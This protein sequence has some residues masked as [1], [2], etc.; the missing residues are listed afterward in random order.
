MV[1][2]FDLMKGVE[3]GELQEHQDAVS[4]LEFWGTTTLITGG[5]DGQVCIWRAQDWELLLKY[6][7]HKAAVACLAVHPSGRLMASSGR[8]RGIRLW[9]LTRGTAAATLSAEDSVEELH[10]SPNGNCIA[11]LSGKELLLVDA[12]NADSIATF[13]N[14]ASA[15]FMRVTLSASAFLADSWLA[16]G[17]GKGDVRIVGKSGN[18]EKQSQQLMEV[19]RLP[20]DAGASRGRVKSMSSAA[21][22]LLVLGMSS[23]SVEVWSYSPSKLTSKEGPKAA[24]FALVRTVDTKVRLTCLTVWAAAPAAEK[25]SVGKASE[26]PAAKKVV[27]KLKKKH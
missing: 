3:L 9:D 19:C 26:E 12:T 27:K 17:D 22:G 16:V 2:L 15:G 10:W 4:C 1:R 25:Q 11:A 13:C 7:A 24:D 5:A 8:D 6:R 20:V 21:Q 23:G 18:A 14:P